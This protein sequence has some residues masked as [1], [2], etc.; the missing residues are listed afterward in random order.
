[1]YISLQDLAGLF[2]FIPSSK[3]S[4][5]TTFWSCAD[6]QVTAVTTNIIK[7]KEYFIFHIQQ[8]LC[9]CGAYAYLY[10]IEQESI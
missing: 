8:L 2:G 6:P 4:F 9:A 3:S 1:M 5:S 10:S 7:E